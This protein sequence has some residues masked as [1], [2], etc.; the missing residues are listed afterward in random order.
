MTDLTNIVERLRE[1]STQLHITAWARK[2]GG[3][4]CSIAA[5]LAEEAADALVA[6]MK[7][8][9]ALIEAL[10]P[11]AE[12]ADLL[13]PGEKDAWSIWEHPVA[14]DIRLS[15]LRAARAL[16]TKQEQDNG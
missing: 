16:T 9:A 5:S 4:D 14:L 2:D 7:R 10:K 12:A 11:F 13:E 15:D 6:S 1:E 3:Q 8:E